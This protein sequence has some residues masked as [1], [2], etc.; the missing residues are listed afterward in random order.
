[1]AFILNGLF[2][3]ELHQIMKIE[4][5]KENYASD[6]PRWLEA[7]GETDALCSL[8]TYAYNHPGYTYPQIATTSFRM[9]AE[10][11]GHPLMHR[12]KCVRNDIIMQQRPFFLIITGANMAGKSTYL[13]TTAVNYL[14]ACM[15]VPVCADKMEFY[16]AKLVTGLRTSDSLNDNE[17]YFF[18][19]LKRLKFIVDELRAGEELF[20]ILDEILKGTNST[21]K[22][23]GSFALI[24]QLITLQTNG[25]IATHDLQL[26][27]L[28]DTFPENIQNF[29]FE[30]EI[31]NNELTFS[32]Q[33]KKG[34]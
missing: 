32:Y 3:R 28:A 14:L 1:V 4:A 33:L 22:Q 13:R 17:S 18:A 21:D 15:G 19:E 30:A 6:L 8:A 26:G 27:T 9:C 10:A 5:W 24:K 2:F 25:I 20:V 31:N 34:I 29:C 23:K 12:E 7:V 11:M 16:P